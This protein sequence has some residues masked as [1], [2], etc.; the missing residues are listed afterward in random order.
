MVSPPLVVS[1]FRGRSL[2]SHS[3]KHDVHAQHTRNHATKH[4]IETPP[5]LYAQENTTE[6]K[7]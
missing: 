1:P 6:H 4:D 3:V 5:S 7:T 2:G